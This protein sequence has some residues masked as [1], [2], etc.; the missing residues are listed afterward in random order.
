L[1]NSN[2]ANLDTDCIQNLPE[3]PSSL[4][5]STYSAAEIA[6]YDAKPLITESN[7]DY[8]YVHSTAGGSVS[9][10]SFEAPGTRNRIGTTSGGGIR[11]KIRGFSR[12]SRRNLLRL[13]ASINRTAFRA[14]KGRVFS[15]TL[16]Y[17]TDYPEDPELCK[18]HLE[19][20]LKR[21]KREYGDFASIWRMG[22][23][24]RGAWHFHLL[25]FV[26]PSTGCTGSTF[27]GSLKEIRRFIAHS[28]YEAC[29]EISE[30]HLLY[31]TYVE[32]IKT[33]RKATSYAEKYM[34]KEE[35][36][37]EDVETGRIWGVWH[38]KALPIQWKT[39]KVT[40]KDAF[41]IRRI[42]RRLA[43]RKG[44]GPLHRMTIFVRY[45]NVVKLLNFLGY[46]VE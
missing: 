2:T 34:A 5:Y 22:I 7:Q 13:L 46:Q 37:P 40:L 3:D 36:F 11:G 9:Q 33:W 16:T 32:E 10:I 26:P 45:E 43:G 14:F 25:L 23:Q 1:N 30:G 19:A 15:A 17:P 20:L 24:K 18:K 12:V 8:A 35:E 28:W 6:T 44:S 39:V 42:Y 31:G 29:G 41:K 27:I 4:D 21:L 38:K